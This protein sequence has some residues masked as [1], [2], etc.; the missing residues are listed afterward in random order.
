MWTND[1]SPIVF[2]RVKTEVERKLKA[3][4][5]GLFF[6]TSDQARVDPKFPTVYV[7][8]M[9]SVETGQD[10]EGSEI[11]AVFASFQIEVTDNQ[12][13][14]RVAAVMNEVV[15]AM[16]RMRFSVVSMPEFQNRQDV[17]RQIARFRRVI[18]RGDIL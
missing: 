6:T 9:G 14:D 10:L 7:H 8:E 15:G 16:K 17:Y 11:N 3:K 13:L 1:I 2:T 18:G 5:P 12:S 4:Y